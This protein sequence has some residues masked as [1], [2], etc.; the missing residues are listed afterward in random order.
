MCVILLPRVVESVP[1]DVMFFFFNHFNY[2]EKDF[3]EEAKESL[4]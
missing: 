1:E 4:F 3:Y 2:N